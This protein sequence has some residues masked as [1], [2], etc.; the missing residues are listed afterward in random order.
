MK[1]NKFNIDRKPLS[2]EEIAKGKD[3]GQILQGANIISKPF[4]KANW[5]IANSIVAIVAVTTFFVYQN[6]KEEPN[7]TL[8]KADI[9]GTAFVKPPIKNCEQKAK[10]YSVNAETGGVINH[11]SGSKIIVPE[12]A[13]VDKNGK[14]VTG[15]VDITY[16]EMHDKPDIF[17]A[18]IPMEYDSAGTIYNLESA[19]MVEIRG[20]KNG[21]EVSIA[22][23]KSLRVNLASQYPGTDYNVYELDTTA[24]NWVHKGKDS[25]ILESVESLLSSINEVEPITSEAEA[26]A[27]EIKIKTE[28]VA[29]QNEIKTLKKSAPIEPIKAT[30]DKWTFNIEVD[31]KDFPE[32][33]VYS[34]TM[35]EVDES[36]KK[37]NPKHSE[38]EWED[39][40]ISKNNATYSIMF[41]NYSQ[42]I[43]YDAKPV[44]AGKYYTSA[45]QIFEQKFADYS[46]KLLAR[47]EQEAVLQSQLAHAKKQWLDQEAQRKYNQAF[48]AERRRVSDS[49]KAAAIVEYEQ[50]A[51][52]RATASSITRSFTI[53]NFGV[54]NC[55]RATSIENKKHSLVSFRDQNNK[56]IEIHTICLVNESRNSIYDLNYWK[57]KETNTYS[58]NFNAFA[59]N[60]IWAVTKD[61]K[62]AVLKTSDFKNAFKDEKEYREVQLTILPQKIT[63]PDEFKKLYENNFEI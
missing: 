58:L 56:P 19:G 34:N 35:W 22:P 61:N 41:S 62:V 3:F 17:L 59:K 2:S 1:P 40:T 42:K 39:V 32:I 51:D 55:D 43:S 31:E 60:M 49:M 10:T 27:Q 26:K 29:V 15:N 14:T 5:F 16:K 53:D 13:F 36:T 47:K 23:G 28:L 57:N 54:W 45:K 25:V 4:Y 6:L 48:I 38:I 9:F 63:H 33:A 50:T 30:S 46:A 37:F 20:Y 52:Q 21:K 44:Y 11:E 8:V 18:G 7:K 24:R 12:K